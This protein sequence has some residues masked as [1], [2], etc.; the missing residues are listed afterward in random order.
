MYTVVKKYLVNFDFQQRN[1]LFMMFK[2]SNKHIIL[3]LLLCTG[4]NLHK[5][6]PKYAL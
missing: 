6:F 4:M 3:L 5:D 2:L 1:V